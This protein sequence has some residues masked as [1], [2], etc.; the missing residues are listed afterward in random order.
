MGYTIFQSNKECLVRAAPASLRNSIM[1]LLCRPRLMVGNTTAELGSLTAVEI[2]GL[3][4]QN[5]G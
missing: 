1:T 4:S 3:S 5:R 2:I